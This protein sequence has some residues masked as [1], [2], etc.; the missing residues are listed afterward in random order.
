MIDRE[1]YTFGKIYTAVHSYDESIYVTSE[2]STAP[3]SFPAVYVEQTDSYNPS[4]YT[5]VSSYEEIAARVVTTV[6]VYSNKISGKRKE[7]KSILTVIDNAL[8]ADG[9]R[10][11]TMN[12]IDL[13]DSNNKAIIRLLARYERLFV[14][15]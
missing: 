11:T 14:A 12:Y 6:E 7:A 9:Y 1:A 4:E 5:Q 8:R 3:P 2:K 13:S 10:R 15:E